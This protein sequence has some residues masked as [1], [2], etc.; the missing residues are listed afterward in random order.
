M[1]KTRTVKQLDP[2]SVRALAHPLR[3]RIV[4][5]LRIHGPA[6]ATTLAGRLGESSGATSYHLRVLAE[7]GFVEEE[8]GRGTGRE[9]WWRAAQE[10]TSWRPEDFRGDA[11]A[12]A[13]EEWLIGHQARRAME[14]IDEWLARRPTAEPE[15]VE[16]A[17]QSDYWLRMTPDQV[18]AMVED[19]HAVIRRHIDETG[20]AAQPSDPEVEAGIDPAARLVRLFLFAVPQ[21]D[22]PHVDDPQIDE[23][24]VDDPPG[25][26]DTP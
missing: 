17:D 2:T 3:V 22:E 16:A 23:P 5:E 25:A 18:E 7:H 9:R 20:A 4:G 1:P 21:V 26:D 13:A 24:H 6:T 11:E 14:W 19:V 10:V 12:E 8:P 15:W